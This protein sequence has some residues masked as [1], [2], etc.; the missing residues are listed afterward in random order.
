M[1]KFMN[2][3]TINQKIIEIFESILQEKVEIDIKNNLPEYGID[4]LFMVQAI[5]LFENLFNIKFDDADLT[6][7][8]TIEN[9]SS[10]IFEKCNLA[11][12]REL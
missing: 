4:S 8:R 7:F 11:E 12:R 10:Y 6:T 1:S 3:Q 9:L 5:V 2:I